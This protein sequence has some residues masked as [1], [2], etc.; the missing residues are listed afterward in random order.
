MMT[1]DCCAH[2][3][4]I[5]FQ[6]IMTLLVTSLEDWPADVIPGQVFRQRAALRIAERRGGLAFNGYS[7]D[8]Y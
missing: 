3:S 7:S 8:I 4:V 5:T 2:S 1:R 6:D